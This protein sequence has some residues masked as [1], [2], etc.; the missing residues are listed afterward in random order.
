MRVLKKAK[1]FAFQKII[2][3][4]AASINFLIKKDMARPI[5]ETPILHGK[6]AKRFLERMKNPKKETPEQIKQIWE[7]Y[8][9][10]MSRFVTS[11]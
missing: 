2:S 11:K 6:A 1:Y 7:D 5:K 3:I 9:F 8:L 10:C 4:F